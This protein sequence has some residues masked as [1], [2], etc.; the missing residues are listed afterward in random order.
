MV[1]ERVSQRFIITAVH[2]AEVAMLDQR[3]LSLKRVLVGVAIN[4]KGRAGVND[5]LP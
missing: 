5:D 3:V 1:K 2:N 4:H